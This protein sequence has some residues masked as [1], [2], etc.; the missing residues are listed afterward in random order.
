MKKW[1]VFGLM[2][3]FT[4]LLAGHADLAEAKRFGMGSSFGK[5]RMVTPKQHAPGFAQQR[6][7]PGKAQGAQRGSARGGFMGMLGGLAL[8]G[9]LGAIFF[10]GA[11]EGINL[12]DIL[13]I[14]GVIALILM[15]LRRKAAPTQISHAYA[16]AEAYPAPPV[17]PAA[18]GATTAPNSHA[19]GAALHPTIDPAHFL[20]AAKEIYMRM[21]K[22]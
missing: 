9:L 19:A 10:G 20:P 14:G 21:Q 18:T 17:E 8:G 16:G 5:H 7:T 4:L 13:V 12:F 1:F 22:A 3:A 11:F 2:A 6:A 15:F